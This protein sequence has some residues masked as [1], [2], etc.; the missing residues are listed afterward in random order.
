MTTSGLATKAT[1]PTA[2]AAAQ[3]AVGS[4]SI[5]SC[6]RVM[7]ASRSRAVVKVDTRLRASLKDDAKVTLASAC[8]LAATAHPL[9]AD[10]ATLNSSVG[11][12]LGSVFAGALV[13]TVLFG[14]VTVVAEFDPLTRRR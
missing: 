4:R 11:S 12:L 7:H 9:A 5:C 14:A 3:V 8:A 2:A 10:A 13:L 6:P 1:T